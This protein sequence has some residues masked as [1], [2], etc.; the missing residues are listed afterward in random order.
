[1]PNPDTSTR[2]RH[3]VMGFA[4]SGLST[5]AEQRGRTKRVRHSWNASA[6]IIA[7]EDMEASELRADWYSAMVSESSLS[8]SNRHIGKPRLS[9]RPDQCG[10][11]KESAVNSFWTR[12]DS[13]SQA[14]L[15]SQI[16]QL[17]CFHKPAAAELR[18]AS[19][20]LQRSVGRLF[21]HRTC[22]HAR[23]A[24]KTCQSRIRKLLLRG[25]F[26]EQGHTELLHHRS[27]RQAHRFHPSR[28]VSQASRYQHIFSGILCTPVLPTDPSRVVA[29]PRSVE[30]PLQ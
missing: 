20:R 12:E 27:L 5:T 25:I 30:Y 7:L 9:L 29:G 1:M 2:Y 24:W 17:L 13:H 4:G 26:Q 18:H 21:Q 28:R 3:E 14:L 19:G 22:R 23:S 15:P 8:M 10:Y 16:P 11:F 6:L